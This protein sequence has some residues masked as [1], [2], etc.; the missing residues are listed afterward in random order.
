MVKLIPDLPG[1]IIGATAS[2]QVSASDYETVLV[3]AV[4]NAIRQHGSVRF[5]YHIGKEFESYSPGAMWDDMK[6]GFAHLKAWERLAVV[7]DHDWLAGAVRGF[8]FAMPCPVQVFA[9]DKYA[10]ALA[11]ITK[12]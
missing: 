5:L 10:E 6:L 4:E 2:G 11:W 7:T 12:D 9:N 8:A 3:P 1:N